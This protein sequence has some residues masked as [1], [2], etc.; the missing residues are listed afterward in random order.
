MKVT[1]DTKEDSH[2]DIQKVLHILT[3][4][5]H[6]KENVAE[7]VDTTNMMTMF[8]SPEKKVEDVAPSQETAPNF[9]S[10]L[11]LVSKKEEKKEPIVELF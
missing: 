9:N 6:K 7:P 11:N 2:E 4:M 10:F 5:L 1:I 8:K 3:N